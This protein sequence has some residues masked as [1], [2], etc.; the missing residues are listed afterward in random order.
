MKQSFLC[1]G[2]F[3]DKT[4]I[5]WP[6]NSQFTQGKRKKNTVEFTNQGQEGKGRKMSVTEQVWKKQLQRT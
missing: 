5:S 4:D 6:L 1:E 3:T 2:S